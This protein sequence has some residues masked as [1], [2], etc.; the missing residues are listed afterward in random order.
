MKNSEFENEGLKPSMK[1]RLVPLAKAS[2]GTCN[3]FTTRLSGKKVFVKEVKPEFAND[4]RMHAA[5]RKEGEIGFRLDHPNL[6]KYI[7]AEGV[8]PPERYIVQEFIDGLA[9]P[10][11]IQENPV[12]FRNKKNLSNFIRELADVIDYLHRNGIVHLDLKP[13]NI[14]ITRVGHTLKLVDLGFCASDFYDD[15]RGFTS[16]ELAPEGILNPQARGAESD[17]YGVGKILRYVRSHTPGLTVSDFRKLENRLLHHDPAKRLSSKE[18]IEKILDRI[19]RVRT[20]WL[21]GVTALI[22]SALVLFLVLDFDRDSRNV[23]ADE[24][25]E[26]QELP[27]VKETETND[28]ETGANPV[29]H[30]EESPLPQNEESGI[31]AQNEISYASY[32]NLKAE[33]VENIN[34]NFVDLEKLLTDYL[35]DGKF[36]D[37][38]YKTVSDTY[39][40]ALQKTFETG[41]YKAK[42]KDLSPSLIDDTM[43]GLL[44]EI[45]KT[46]WGPAYKKFIKEYQASLSASSR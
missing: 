34:K 8:L 22:I 7:Y 37:E 19:H 6:P 17:Y 10:N 36:T 12:Y 40:T 43:A 5:F 15:T 20:A 35:R 46:S 44:Q 2:G 21:A 39:N 1:L 13:E 3:V 4:A 45:E 14:L 42:Y 18:A 29:R 32:E 38:D 25:V 27:V 26:N 41:P 16:A 33:M 23:P 11:F 30:R 9:L 24:P 28:I 31:P